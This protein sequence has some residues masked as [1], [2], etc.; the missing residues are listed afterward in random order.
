MC[1]IQEKTINDF[2]QQV[3]Y[4]IPETL[5]YCY[6]ASKLLRDKLKSKYDLSDKEIKIKEVHVGYPL[7]IRHYVIKLNSSCLAKDYSSYTV[8]IDVTLDQYCDENYK[9]DIVKQTFGLKENIP[10]VNIFKPGNT[11]YDNI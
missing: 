8:L 7:K 9:A 4:E 2:G 6:E 5:G 3:R 10:N 1:S 11:P